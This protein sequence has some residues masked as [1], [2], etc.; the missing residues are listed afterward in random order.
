MF[1]AAQTIYAS[2][3]DGTNF[4]KIEA[5]STA[6]YDPN[7]TYYTVASSTFSAYENTSTLFSTNGWIENK[8][9]EEKAFKDLLNAKI[10]EG[11]IEANSS[12][13]NTFAKVRFENVGSTPLIIND[14]IV[15]AILFPTY[16]WGSYTGKVKNNSIVTLD[17]GQATI[18]NLTSDAFFRKDYGNQLANMTNLTLPLTKKTSEYNESSKQDE[19]K[20]VLATPFFL[21]LVLTTRYIQRSS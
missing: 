1:T 13:T 5:G 6:V 14:D 19:E 7:A 4:T 3:D 12:V 18:E 9:S 8:T 11:A 16:H 15:H 10:L 20:M 17:L 2:T 21:H